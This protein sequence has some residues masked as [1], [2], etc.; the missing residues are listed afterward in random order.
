[1]SSTKEYF[2]GP[3]SSDFSGAPE[4]RYCGWCGIELGMYTPERWKH[5]DKLC[6]G[7]RARSKAASVLGRKGGSQT[8]PPK[9]A[10]AKRNIEKRWAIGRE[11]R[12]DAATENEH[13]DDK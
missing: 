10:A 12:E 1:M 13:K 5:A 7:C 11:S 8:S 3:T 6:R 9:R 2:F 4:Q